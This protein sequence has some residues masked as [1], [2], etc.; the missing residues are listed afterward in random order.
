MSFDCLP[1]LWLHLPGAT[2]IIEIS[3]FCLMLGVTFS[4]WRLQYESKVL[5][6]VWL[7]LVEYNYQ[8]TVHMM[9]VNVRKY[10]LLFSLNFLRCSA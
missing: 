4:S 1:I 7:T 6:K 2:E 10:S 8:C 9:S 5:H 3:I